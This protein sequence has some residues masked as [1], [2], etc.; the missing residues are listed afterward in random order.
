MDMFVVQGGRPLAGTVRVSGSKNATLPIMAAALAADGETTLENVPDLVDVRTLSKLLQ[1]LGVAVQHDPSGRMTLRPEDDGSSTAD[2][3]LVRQMR[4]SVC[5]LGP[6]LARRGH[7]CVSLPGG[8]NIGHRPIDLH[9]KGLAALGA[10]IEVRGGYVH[11]VAKRLRGAQIYLGGVNGSTVTG[12]CNVMSA[13]ALAE[14]TTVITAA[15]CEPEVVALARFL[16]AMGARITGE[17]T[18]R[19]EIE[20][21]QRITGTKFQIIPDRVEAATLLIAAAIT[22]G[23][24]TLEQVWPDHLTA[25]IEVLKEMGCS[26]DSAAKETLTLKVERPLRPVDLTALPYPGVPTDVQA[27]LM[28]L[29]CTLP[30]ASVIRDMVFPDRFMHV[31]ELCRMGAQIRQQGSMAIVNGVPQLT[32]AH[33]MASDLRASAAL[34]LAGLAADGE[35][36]IRR[37]YH[38]DRG[39][40]QLEAKLEALGADVTRVNERAAGLQLRHVDDSEVAEPKKKSA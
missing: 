9:L 11:A 37:I 38:L 26:I 24:L 36:T 8:C 40:E 13:A 27:Q 16:N 14:G 10:E 6:L 17:G 5:V 20:G 31:S 28:A 34:V 22:G 18:P 1:S 30:G 19:I 21:V 39:Y 35:T 25:V 23:S 2:Y 33:V 32:G 7:A 3:H 29:A 12:T 4:A 15:A